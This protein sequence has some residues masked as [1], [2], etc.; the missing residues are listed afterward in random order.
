M[1]DYL[2][3]SNFLKQLD[4]NHN[5]KLNVRI[6]ALDLSDFPK[7]QITGL[8]TGGS[9][10]IDGASAV[11]RS[12]SL[13]LS[14][15][16]A[17]NEELPLITDTYWCYNNKFKMEIGLNNEINPKYPDII[18]F[19][20][21]IYLITSF[22]KSRS[23]NAYN[24]SISG[25]DKMARL[26]GDISGHI[27]AGT[28]FGT[29]E[30]LDRAT[31]KITITKLTIPTIIRNAI[32]V[33]GQERD[34]N[35]II[36]DLEDTAFE[37]WEYR[38]DK[39]MYLILKPADQYPEV[40]N[41]TFTKPD[42]IDDTFKY[43]SFN[44]LDADYND[45]DSLGTISFGNY[46]CYVAKIEYGETAGYHQTPLVYN[47]DLILNAGETVTG[48][49]DKIKA[50][51]GNFEY[52]YD[53]NG[54]F[55]FQKKH[56]YVQELF[57]PVTGG[58]V[59][60]TMLSTP[61]AYK[62][63]DEE[64][65]T[66]ISNSP[67]IDNVKND[68][69]VWGTR[70]GAGGADLPIHVRYALQT[71]PAN[72]MSPWGR[73]KRKANLYYIKTA[74]IDFTNLP[75]EKRQQVFEQYKSM[76]ELWSKQE[77]LDTF[78]KV[79]DIE[80]YYD[81]LKYYTITASYTDSEGS[82]SEYH[83]ADTGVSAYKQY[84][85]YED[86]TNY[87]QKNLDGS[88]TQ[89]EKPIQSGLDLSNL[90]ECLTQPN[91]NYDS[92]IVPY[93]EVIYQMAVDFYAHNQDTDFL[94]KLAEANPQFPEGKT[95]YE[96]YYIDMQGFW[97]QL[98][99]PDAEEREDGLL[100]DEI[101]DLTYYPELKGE[102]RHPDA[103]WNTAIHSDP[104]SLNFWFNLF[105]SSG[106]LRKYNIENIGTRSKVVNENSV[107]SIYYRETPEVQFIVMPKENNEYKNDSAYSPIWIQ[108]NME[109]MFYR[110][111]QGASAID[112]VNDLIYQHTLI[113]EAITLTS[114]PIYYLQPNTRIH[115]KDQGDCTVDKISYNLNYNGTMSLTCNKIFKGGI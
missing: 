102:E 43:Y 66:A 40:I 60:P 47:A 11:R 18:W 34:E 69:S 39:P 77:D 51:L 108:E 32:K 53:L 27:M 82:L 92:S 96:Q 3:D 13:T 79:L 29:E 84:D 86:Q 4:Y 35:I 74:E 63:E 75:Q 58:F 30:F 19:D 38:G 62:F 50:M 103:Y 113:S 31:G 59:E 71:R 112:K 106:E 93:Q 37:L 48:L 41:M 109:Q 105:D 87:Y 1:K 14:A 21:G 44:T 114:I 78:Y 45:K 100:Y 101:L 80:K 91:T 104:N 73:Y 16:A 56:T 12:C 107:K 36:N 9:I 57:S 26:N 23:T 65:F 6:T 17:A 2:Y 15:A 98:Y 54:R 90:W 110:S 49:L 7:E 28:D 83:I 94:L 10:N 85:A 68:F 61:Y 97:R 67:K 8:V 52:F 64:L 70:K 22:S 55:V 20:M 111:A 115:I 25:K 42:E 95:G 89:L 5:K 99:N 76:T 72:Y 88:Y 33:Y 81:S 24:I 46:D